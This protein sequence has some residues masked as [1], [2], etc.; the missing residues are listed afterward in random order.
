MEWL[1]GPPGLIILLVI[2]ILVVGP[3]QLP[4]LGK[5]LG[6]TMKSVRT[7]LDEMNAEIKSEP[8]SGG[9]GTGTEAVLAV[10]AP[11]VCTHCHAAIE[12]G[13]KFCPECGAEVAPRD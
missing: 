5:Q 1:M 6:A 11:L 9:E 12:A 4:K 7:G 8:T 13:V 2:L 3:K 10:P